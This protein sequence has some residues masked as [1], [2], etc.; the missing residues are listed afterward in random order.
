MNFETEKQGD[1]T[2]VSIVT[3]RLD[4]SV[5]PELKALILSLA[6]AGERRLLLDFDKVEFMDS[7]GLGAVVAGLKAVGDQGDLVVC[8][9]K[10]VVADL[11]KL[12]HMDRV[13]IIRDDR[14]QGLTQLAA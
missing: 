10:G 11:F 9:I 3:P 6:E 2:I 4:A 8:S 7:S 14:A 12:T 1:L 5:A 13:F